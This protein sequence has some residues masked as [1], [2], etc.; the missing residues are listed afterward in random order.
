MKKALLLLVLLVSFSGFS[1][2]NKHVAVN[3]CEI[4]KLA[5]SEKK[6]IEYLHNELPQRSKLYLVKNEFC[7]LNEKLG[8][9]NIETVDEKVIVDK[10]N[11]IKIT[12]LKIE[13]DGKILELYYPM[14]EVVFVVKFDNNDK[15]TD[16]DIMEK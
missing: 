11:Y 10:K 3:N 16:I 6:I 14:E 2:M 15:I 12:S 5:L 13:K 8:K 7:N 1:Q 9:I 4:I